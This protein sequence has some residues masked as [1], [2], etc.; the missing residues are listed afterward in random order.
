LKDIHPRP[1]PTIIPR[2]EHGISRSKVSE[3]A[4]KVLYRLHNAGYMACLVGGGVRDVLLGLA[5]K[6][7]DI[8]T[9]AHPEQ[10]RELFRN[11]RL[12]GRRFRLAHV[13]FGRDVVEVATFR[14]GGDG[15]GGDQQHSDSGR[16]LRDNIYGTI[17]EDIWRRDFTVNALY[18][19]I[20]D[21]SVWD[22]TGGMDDLRTRTLRLIDDPWVR[23]REDPVRMLR[24]AR[25]AAKLGFSIAPETAAPI[26]DLAPHLADVP[27]ARLFDETLKLFQTGNA[28]ASFEQLVRYDLLA[29]LF[30][31]AAVL[32]ARDPGGEDEKFIRAG[33]E[34]TDA[35][36]AED[37]SVTPMFLYGVLLWPGIKHLAGELQTRHGATE[38]EA[39]QEAMHRVVAEQTARTALPKRFSVPMKE[40]LVLQRRFGNRSGVRAQRLLEHKRF[41]AAYDFLVLRAHCGEVEQE[42]ADWWTGVQ[43]SDEPA[44][45]EA[46]ELGQDGKKRP[47]RRS[48]R[49][50]RRRTPA[51]ET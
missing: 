41:R 45:R 18:Y 51:N 4:L 31:A 38:Y 5:P 19:N 27:A 26:R 33:L 21:F 44:K 28:V 47:R 39:M 49:R 23:Y 12:I 29:Y 11:S 15:I 16:I 10:I 6:D 25:F 32:V 35:R 24:A 17:G 1:G 36:I 30:P 22:Y 7:F 14:A 20:A 50:G 43:D 9:D 40:M 42:I 2:S 37:K 13:R 34:N 8:A 48:R 46:F 3:N